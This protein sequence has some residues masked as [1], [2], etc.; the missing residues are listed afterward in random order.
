MTK[1]VLSLFAAGFIAALAPAST[2]AQTSSPSAAVSE[3]VTC[4]SVTNNQSITYYLARHDGTWYLLGYAGLSDAAS[5]SITPS[6]VHTKS[7]FAQSAFDMVLASYL[8]G[9]KLTM[10][11]A[12]HSAT[13]C[14]HAV[15]RRVDL[16]GRWIRF[17]Q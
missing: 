14:G 12:A 15:T 9:R 6:G 13:Y 17:N 10:N 2:Q 7:T 5:A 4:A 11:W 1:L 16:D 3:I 8:S